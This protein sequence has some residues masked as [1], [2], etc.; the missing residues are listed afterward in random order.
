[1]TKETILLV[2]EWTATVFGLLQGL[3]ILL[4]RKENWTF[5][6]AQSVTYVVWA[7]GSG[8][9]A[10][11]VEQGVYI[12]LSILGFSIWYQKLRGK[13]FDVEIHHISLS[14]AIISIGTLS[15][16]TVG[17]YFWLLH[18]NDPAPILDAVTTGIGF[19]ATFL[20]ARKVVECW[21]LWFISDI[22]GCIIYFDI[23][24]PGLIILNFV[25]VFMAVISY[26]TWSKEIKRC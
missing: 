11:V 3:L 24:A 2:L 10:D 8:L 5:L 1:M 26:I 13:I 6:L 17:F 9:Y 21:V 18:T 22:L 14:S 12:L 16:L 4:K 15:V 7:L 19:V 23:S 25:W 20:M